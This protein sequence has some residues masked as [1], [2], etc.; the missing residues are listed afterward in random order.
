MEISIKNVEHLTVEASGDSD[1]EDAIQS[2]VAAQHNFATPEIDT[3]SVEFTEGDWDGDE[4]MAQAPNP[5]DGEDA[6]Q[7]LRRMVALYPTGG[8]AADSKSNYKLPFRESP[9]GPVN[10]N[11]VSAAIAAINGARGGVD[12]PEDDLQTAFNLLV[13]LGVAG[14]LYEDR[15]EAPDFQASDASVQGA[16]K[17]AFRA[18]VTGAGAGG[19]D[20]LSGVVWAAGDHTLHLR[21]HPTP[22]HV[23]E[24]S[25]PRTF[26]NLQAKVE[27]GEFPPLGL[28]HADHL[29]RD[30]VPV[31]A[32]LDVLKIG[33]A[34]GFALSEDG[35]S[36]V[37]TDYDLTN[38]QVQGAAEQLSGFDYSIVGVLRIHTE[39]GQPKTVESG[40]KERLVVTAENV[41]QVDFVDGGAVDGAGPGNKPPVQRAASMAAKAPTERATAFTSSLR[42]MAKQTGDIPMKSLHELEDFDDVEDVYAHAADV[43]EAKDELIQ[44]FKTLVEAAG[45]N[46]DEIDPD[47]DVDEL[48]AEVE[49]L[50]ARADALETLADFHDVDLSAEDADGV[51]ELIDEHTADLREDVAAKE[52]TLPK[53]DT[54]GDD[55]PSVE[56]RAE[57]LKGKSPAELQALNGE[58]ANEILQSEQARQEFGKAFA[59]GDGA[60]EVSGGSG[61]SSGGFSDEAEAM[62]Q[63]AMALDDYQE[64]E[65][66]DH[67]S[68]AEFMAEKYD[69]DPGDF[70]NPDEYFAAT[71]SASGGD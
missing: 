65:R 62:A 71:V 56:E 32:E 3:D 63:E 27:A 51:Q 24:D 40:G 8:E 6:Q 43:V 34:T 46:A 19:G 2:L 39:D 60:G 9:D 49:A 22:V 7:A 29:H 59:S 11:G 18:S 37:M 53:Y 50:Q 41:R 52:S 66:S 57:E 10:L 17:A 12:A 13:R 45:V 16:A 20:D 58:R 64:F 15:D 4:A 33:Q 42:F 26:D 5:S 68:A 14:G 1:V 47:D 55:G 25:I 21:G 69:E 70:D 44:Q 48:V 61:G 54:G 28:D 38:E 67:D 23:P 31:A 35:Q 36:I 30:T